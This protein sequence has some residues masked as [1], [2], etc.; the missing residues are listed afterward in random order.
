MIAPQTEGHLAMASHVRRSW[1]SVL[2][3][4]AGREPDWL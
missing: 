4:A 3:R 2:H 1:K